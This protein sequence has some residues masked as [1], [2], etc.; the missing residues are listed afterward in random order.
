MPV[1]FLSQ[2]HQHAMYFPDN[3]LL[4]ESFTIGQ[5]VSA[6]ETAAAT[7][8][9]SQRDDKSSSGSQAAATRPFAS[10]S[11]RIGYDIP[12]KTTGWHPQSNEKKRSE[13]RPDAR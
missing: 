3:V 9:L 6:I 7:F 13:S 2:P 11:H 1:F 5:E 12:G 8:H 4:K 10:L